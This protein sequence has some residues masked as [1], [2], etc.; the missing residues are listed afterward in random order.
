MKSIP[1]MLGARSQAGSTRRVEERL[2]HDAA[3]AVPDPSP[4]LAPRIL[5]ALRAN[6]QRGADAARTHARG[7]QRLGLVLA[8]AAG[9]LWIALALR[10]ESSGL[11]QAVPPAPEIATPSLSLR[12]PSR[13]IEQFLRAPEGA[14]WVRAVDEPLQREARLLARDGELVARAFLA[15]LP[16]PLRQALER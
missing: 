16:R 15:G 1:E 13:R 2:V 11:P 7:V 10:R 8:G 6:T 14:Q 4:E 9:L 12:P 5:A 3:R